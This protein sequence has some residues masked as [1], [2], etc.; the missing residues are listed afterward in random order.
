METLLQRARLPVLAGADPRPGRSDG[1]AAAPSPC[2]TTCTRKRALCC[3]LLERPTEPAAFAVCNPHLQSFAKRHVALRGRRARGRL[4]PVQNDV[5]RWRI[6]A[7]R[8]GNSGG[9]R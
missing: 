4:L 1:S 3:G 8:T 6:R 5:R 9:L 2:A 7:Y